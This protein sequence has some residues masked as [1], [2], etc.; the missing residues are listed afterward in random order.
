MS[1]WAL[2]L[3]GMTLRGV[4]DEDPFELPRDLLFPGA[5]PAL[6]HRAAALDPLGVDPARDSILLRVQVFVIEHAGRVILVDG[7]IGDGKERPARASWHRRNTDFLHRLGVAPEDVDMLLFTHLHADHVGWA[8][9][10]VEWRWVPTFPKARH[11]VP[12][13]EYAHWEARNATAPANHGSFE[14]SVLPL[15]EAGLLDRVPLDHVPVPGLRFRHLPGH[16]PGQVG[17]LLE[18][19]KRPALIAADAVHHPM[20]LLA[21]RLVSRFCSDPTDAVATR[22]ALL[23]EAAADGLALVPHHARGRRLWQVARDGDAY[24]LKA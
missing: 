21:P 3:G 2:D 9:R 19:A 12:E 22:L 20:Q 23:E 13:V 4:A 17:I 11:V 10:K 7:G 1:D 14:D 5:D 24:T 18:G 16:T 6:L 15:A 8:T